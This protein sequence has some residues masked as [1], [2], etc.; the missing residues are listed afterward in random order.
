M[1][2]LVSNP[3]ALAFV[4]IAFPLLVSPLI[5]GMEM[6]DVVQ[7]VFAPYSYDM[8]DGYGKDG[9][10]LISKVLL[11]IQLAYLVIMLFASKLSNAIS[12]RMLWV[13]G[14]LLV[15]I[16]FGFMIFVYIISGFH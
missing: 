1:G 15:V 9:A 7:L 10:R 11:G 2:K 5:T 4:V 3:V 6:G 8:S 16:Y 12:R 13:I 14:V